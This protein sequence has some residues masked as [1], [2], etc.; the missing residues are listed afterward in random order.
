M[1]CWRRRDKKEQKQASE[2]LVNERVGVL[3]DARIVLLVSWMDTYPP[4]VALG[5]YVVL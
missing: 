4:I 3:H 2:I 5:F 1:G